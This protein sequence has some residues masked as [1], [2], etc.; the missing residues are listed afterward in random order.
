MNNARCFKTFLLLLWLFFVP[1]SYSHEGNHIKTD[2]LFIAHETSESQAFREIQLELEAAGISYRT[3]AIGPAADY[4]KNDPTLI[5][6]PELAPPY[7][8][9][10]LNMI[11]WSINESLVQ[12]LSERVSP[13][14][15]YTGMASRSQAQ[16][17]NHWAEK[18]AK[19]FVFYDHLQPVYYTDYA[20]TFTKEIK[21]VDAFHAPNKVVAI[22][23]FELAKATGAKV[24]ITGHPALQIS[25]ETYEQT[26]TIQLLADLNI[27]P[28]QKVMLF[29]ADTSLESYPDAFQTFIET[30]RLLPHILFIA[31]T[32]SRE[33]D[34][35][36]MRMI[37]EGLGNIL[38]LND[39]HYSHDTLMTISSAIIAHSEEQIIHTVYKDKTTVYITHD[40][41][42]NYMLT[43]EAAFQSS[44]PR[45]LAVELFNATTYENKPLDVAQEIPESFNHVIKHL[46]ID[47]LKQPSSN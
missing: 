6:T 21:K 4:F 46:I 7:R 33:R 17:A 44:V 3:V 28:D 43:A 23:L 9:M 38:V 27:H 41:S 11:N 14:I 39:E 30:T 1:V 40:N 19:I 42:R 13:K 20:Q 10:L 31:T 45:L 5:Q 8:F 37:E 2:V 15:V 32:N 36:E 34:D 22:S 26:D 25:R 12:H 47:K 29:A 35:M 18:G 16:I 24:E